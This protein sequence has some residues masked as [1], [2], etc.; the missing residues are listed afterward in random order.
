MFKLHA[1]DIVNGTVSQLRPFG[2]F[3]DLDYSS[4]VGLVELLSIHDDPRRKVTELP[5]V[6]SRVRAVFLGFGGGK[7]TDLRL[8]MQPSRLAAA[9]TIERVR[10]L[11]E[12][13]RNPFLTDI[14]DQDDVALAEAA[15]WRWHLL[16][17]SNIRPFL[18]HALHKDEPRVNGQALLQ[19]LALKPSD[20]DTILSDA[21]HHDDPAIRELAVRVSRHVG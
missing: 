9:E 18:M 5:A 15:V 17:E 3:I 14:L 11:P 1:G 16:P 4:H 19:A 10:A 7:G 13:A 2:A 20:R 12:Q 8:S 21:L 6:G